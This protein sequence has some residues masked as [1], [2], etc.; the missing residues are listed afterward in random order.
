MKKTLVA[1][2]VLAAA[3]SVQAIELYNQDGVTVDMRGDIEVTYQSDFDHSS[4]K[5][6]IED[7]DFGF[8]VRYAIDDEF[9]IGTYW[10]YNGS[11]NNN[12]AITRNGDTYVA[13][14]T[15]SYGSIKFGRLCTAV[16]DLGGI[17]SDY[18]FDVDNLA[19]SAASDI[20]C[21]DEA[22]RYDFDNGSFYTTLGFVQD[23]VYNEKLDNAGVEA[24][25]AGTGTDYFDGRVGYRVNDF[26]MSV[27]YASVDKEAA[28]SDETGYGAEVNFTGIENVRLGAGYYATAVDV[29]TG[30]DSKDA[31]VVALGA[32]YYMDKWTFGAGYSVA[33][34]DVDANDV[35]KWFVNAGYGIAPNTTVY[36]EFA[37][38]DVEG[39][40]ETDTALAIGVKAEF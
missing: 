28:D 34:Y 10:E 20:T 29:A 37:G 22:V 25:S 26:D 21:G 17:T 39:E 35:D 2:S 14:Y 6:E 23:K 18:Q 40:S 12:A 16:D 13:L 31:D 36:A 19:S 3:T 33:S 4:M 30:A 1:L 24:G 8:D 11:D 38:Q 15:K 5:Q 9:T 7:A 27:F 32:D